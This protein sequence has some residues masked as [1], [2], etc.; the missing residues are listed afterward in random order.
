MSP[1]SSLHREAEIQLTPS[2]SGSYNLSH[3]SIY[4]NG[5]ILPEAEARISVLDRGLLYG[6]GVFEGLRVYGSRPFL[7]RE[8]VA[9]LFESARVILLEAG[10]SAEALEA[11][12]LE[13]VKANGIEEG[14]VRMVITRGV[15]PLGLS[16]HRCTKPSV[17][18]IATELEGQPSQSLE[19]VTCA[20]RRPAP[21]AAGPRV[22]SLSHLTNVMAKMECQHAGCE[23]GIM[24]NEQGYVADCTE[25]SIFVVK[26]GGLTTPSIASGALDSVV[27][28]TVLG[29]ASELGLRIKEDLMT[30]HEIYTSS[31]C[32]IVGATTEVVPVVGLDRRRL[33]DGKAG[34]VTQQ[35]QAAFA[36]LARQN[37]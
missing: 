37:S 23:E 10:L 35:I 25:A 19:L 31:E 34:P 12:V 11:A 4:L 7:L 1:P 5:Q 24:L 9:K 14:H 3:R 32:F 18:I 13:T 30:R 26:G 28:K 36:Q 33:G 17:F 15:G 16:T 2:P 29:L 20:T 8:H 22:S 6:D 27:R 21:S